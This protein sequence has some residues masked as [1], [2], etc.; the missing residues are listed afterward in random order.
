MAALHAEVVRARSK[1]PGNRHKLAALQEECGELARAMLQRRGADIF[2][3]AIQVASTALRIAEEG[4]S[5]FD[6]VT[7][8]EAQP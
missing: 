5:A 2:K 8:E 4:D 3:E 6:D 1:F 7:D